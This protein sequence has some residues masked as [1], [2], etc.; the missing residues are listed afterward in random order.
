MTLGLSPD[1]SFVCLRMRKRDS[2]IITSGKCKIYNTEL[3]MP[4]NNDERSIS[5]FNKCTVLTKTESKLFLERKWDKYN[6]V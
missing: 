6:D 5:S 1:I 3:F 4:D 2:S